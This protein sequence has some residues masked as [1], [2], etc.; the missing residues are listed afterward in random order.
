MATR[1]GEKDE[2]VLVGVLL[3][4]LGRDGVKIYETFVFTDALDAKKI[5][6]VLDNFSDY[7]EPIKC[8]VFDRFRFHKRHQ[9]RGEP[10]D[11]WLVELRSLVKSC[12][13]GNEATVNSILRDEI[14]LGVSSDTVREKLLYEHGLSLTSTCAI[15]RACESSSSQL[16]QITLRTDAV[17]AVQEKPP[18][19]SRQNSPGTTTQ[20]GFVNCS[21]CGR[22]HRKGD[23][24][25]SGITCYRC[26]Q[27]GHYAR[28]CSHPPTQQRRSYTDGRQMAPPPSHPTKSPKPIPAQ[29]GTFMQQQ[30]H[31]IEEVDD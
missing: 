21:N 20:N 3:T 30:L 12:N 22:R 2:D 13:Y 24:S 18:D 16:S 25:A 6:P 14:V 11:S 23:C 31:S 7:F 26:G 1:K 28:R 5:K 15:V 19:R 27:P 9:Q 29:R 17:H 4:L 8:E 10:F